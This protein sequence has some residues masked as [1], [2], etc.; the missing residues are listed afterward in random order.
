MSCSVLYVHKHEL[1][2]AEA[3]RK[4]LREALEAIYGSPY[5]GDADIRE[6]IEAV[7]EAD[8]KQ[9]SFAC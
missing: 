8:A 5:M 1:D 7:L 2:V 4:K 6:G 3:K 9:P